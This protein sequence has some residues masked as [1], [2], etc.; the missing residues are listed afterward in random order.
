[1]P[2]LPKTL[3]QLSFT[4]WELPRFERLYAHEGGGSE[5][6]PRAQEYLPLEM[7]KLSQALEQ[8][9]PPWQMDTAAFL[10]SVI[11][12]GDSPDM[13]CSRLKRITLH[14]SLPVPDSSRHYFA[15]LVILAARAALS[16]P[17][18]EV[19]ELWGAC[20]DRVQ[21]SAYI[22]RYCYEGGRPTIVWRSSGEA[23]VARPRIMAS[24]GEVA[25]KYSGSTLACSIV[26]LPFT[27]TEVFKS[28][29]TSIYRHLMLK[30]LV[31]DPVTQKVLEKES[32][33]EGLVQQHGDALHSNPPNPASWDGIPLFEILGL[34]ED[35]A[36]LQADVVA[37][38]AEVNTFFQ[39]HHS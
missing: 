2:S 13:P 5:F 30:E 24:W 27:R 7:A 22:F 25:E 28:R 35:L 38:D 11:E 9:C 33:E 26:P 29:G 16:L 8:L 4:Q 12:L 21:S 36:T 3:R 14:C 17:Q 32:C 18:M 34:D 15:S 31:F 20:V 23:M 37:F 19:M 10:Q 39:Q 1:M 6:S